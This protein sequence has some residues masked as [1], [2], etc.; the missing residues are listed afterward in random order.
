MFTRSAQIYDKI[1]GFKDYSAASERIAALIEAQ[2]PEAR[3][4]IDIGCGTGKHLSFLQERYEVEGLDLNEELIEIAR[5]TCP[6]VRFTVA[7]MTTFDLSRTFDVTACLFS[8]IGYVKT[9]EGLRNA[10]KQLAQH[11]NP[12]GL[13]LV[14]PWFTPEQFWTDHITANYVD[15]PDLKITW[16]YTSRAENEVSILDIHYLVGTPQSVSHFVERHEIGLFTA[17]EYEAAFRDAGLAV[18]FDKQGLFQ[19]GLYIGRK[20]R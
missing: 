5:R 20:A 18:E 11:T 9:K 6:E 4:L 19:R 10:L 14:E 13:V 16:M 17:E 3:S 8:A 12:S 15:E 1:Y 7:D 2:H